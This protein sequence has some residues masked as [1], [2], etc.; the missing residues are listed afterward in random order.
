M[1]KILLITKYF[2]PKIG[3][4]QTLY[5]NICK[6][7]K[8]KEIFVLTN[9]V[10]GGKRFDSLQKFK[11][12]RFKNL[13]SLDSNVFRDIYSILRI[14]KK[15]KINNIIFGHIDYCFTALLLKFIFG[16]DYYLYIHGEEI[17]RNYGGKYYQFFKWK[18]LKY[19][20]GI[21]VVSENTKKLVEKY[22]QNIKVIYNAVDLKQFYP[23]K[24]NLAL[25][26]KHK[27][28]NK[29]IILTVGR[30]ED[31]KGHSEVIR[32][33]PKLI[34]KHDDLAYLII[35]S[36]QEEGKLRLLVRK[37]KL[38]KHVKFLSKVPN[39][40]LNDYYNLCDIFVMP[41]R[42]TKEGNT[43]GF[44]IVF[45]EA[46]A[47][48]KPVIGG[49]FGGVPSAIKEGYNGFLVNNSKELYNRFMILLGD[50][51]LRLNLGKNA[52]EWAKRFTYGKLIKELKYFLNK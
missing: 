37:L 15:E 24:K 6:N 30:L 32:V 13:S 21:I 43:E 36:G 19:A 51:V 35:G 16:K 31:R 29:K 52:L 44:G 9:K 23:K 42:N 27:L 17:S 41:N 26:K 25:I 34:K 4:T 48:G 22:N 39:K 1:N 8:S 28:E 33:L 20:K 38:E 40:K 18:S 2:P 50:E 7:F 45:L 12:S 5:Y 46:N 14:I 11:I 3:G 10:K 49:N 47:C